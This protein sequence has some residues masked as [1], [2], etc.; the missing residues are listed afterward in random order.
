MVAGSTTANDSNGSPAP[1][2]LTNSNDETIDFG[3]FKATINI[4]KLTNGTNNDADPTPGVPDGPVVPVGSTVTWTYNVTNPT[5]VAL[6]NVSVTDNI[7]GVNP[8]PVLSGGFNVG[9]SNHDGL[10]EM[11]ETWVFTASGTAI[12]GQYSNI[13]TTTGTP[14]TPTGGSIPG[15]TPVTANNPDHYYGSLS[16]GDFVW[17]DTNAN[18]IQDNNDLTGNGINGVLVDLLDSHGTQ[19]ASTTTGNNPVGGAP[20]YYQFSGLLQGSYTVVIDASNF[21]SGGALF[22]YTATPSMVAGSTTA[23]DSNGSPAPV[24]LTNANDETIDFGYFKATINIVK[25]TNGTNNDS[26]P[27]PGVPDGPTV[28]V[29]STV[30]WTYNVTNPTQVALSN[31]SVTDNIAG[32]NPTPVLSGGFNVGDSNHDGLLEMGETWVFTASGTAIAGQYSN[33]GTTTG[34]PVTPTGGSIPGATPVTANNPDHY[35]GT[36][37][38]GDFIWND[39]N[40]N[41][42]QDSN[43]LTGNGINGVLVDLKNSGGTVIATTITGNNPVGGAPGYYQFSGLLQ[44]TYTVVIDSSNFAS[45]GPLAGYTVTPSNAPGSTTA[46]DSNGSPA[47]VTLTNANDETIDFGYYK[48]APPKPG[49]TTTPSGSTNLCS[50]SISGFKFLDNSG[51]GFSSDDTGKG[52]VTINL[53]EET[54]GTSGLQS[55]GDMLVATTMTLG[56]GSYTFN[57][58]APGTYYVQE[59]VPTGYIQ[60]GGGP[61]GPA[62]NTYF[63]VNATSGHAYANYDFDDFMLLTCKPTN[64]SY[65][66]TAPNGSYQTVSDMTGKTVQGATV[67][68]TFT[69]TMVPEMLTLASY[70]APSASFSDSNA[71]QQIFFQQA[72][73]T[74]TTPGT[75][76]LT[77]KIPNC[78]YQ[79]DF[80]CGPTID[81]LEPNQN[82]NAYGPD[83]A[84]ILYTPQGRLLDADNGGTVCCSPM[85]PPVSKNYPTPT[86]TSTCSSVS[87]NDSATISGGVNPKGTV[88]FYLM[89]PGST[90]STPLTSAVYTDVVTIGT[91]SGAMTGNGTYLTASMGNNP[92]GFMAATAGTYQWVVVYSSSDANN[93]SATSPFGNEPFTVGTNTPMISTTPGGTVIIGCG[94]KLTDSAML[95]AGINPGGTITFYLMGPGATSSTP[96]SAAV[97]TDTVTVNGNGTYS[98]ASGNYPG[99]YLPTAAGTYQWIAVYSGDGQN[100]PL[101]SKFGD[102][103]EAAVQPI[104]IGG[105]VFCDNNLNGVL[106]SGETLE[107]GAQVSLLSGTTVLQTATTGSNGKY[108][109]GNLP[110]GTYTVKLTSPSAGDLAEQ[111]HGAVTVAQSYTMTL[112]GGGSSTANNFAQIDQGS[113]SG[114]VFGDINDSGNCDSGEGPVAGA[115]VAL[116]GTDYLGN[117]VSKTTTTNSS[118]QFSFTGLLP[119]NASGYAVKVTPL[120]G[121]VSGIDKPGN[122]GGTAVLN[123]DGSSAGTISGIVLPGCNNCAVNYNFGELSIC[124]GLTATI[125]FWHN[126]NGQNLIKSFGTTSSGQS[127]ANW[128][129]TTYPNLF[130]NKAPAFSVSSTIGTNLTGRSNT[131]VAN[132]F[133]SLFGVS[134]QKAYAQVL[135]TALSVFT[136]TSTL[137]TGNV[138]YSGTT[139]KALATKFGFAISTVGGGAANVIVPSADWAAFGISSSAGATKTVSLLLSLAN[140][141]AVSGKLNNGNA[142]LITETNDL[143]NTIN[144]LGNIH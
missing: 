111:S 121:Q 130:G 100:A 84:N 30:T 66:I 135:A 142:T 13:G 64:V 79:I 54:N 62:G 93:S 41:G 8:T 140:Q 128:L 98:T 91:N 87:L 32:V 42:I 19:I 113:V 43:D 49:L 107:S 117:A 75:Y 68:V 10:L 38:L 122:F 21:N 86:V 95:A 92:G 31:V 132:Y 118:G 69:V 65:K 60:T 127:L 138:T 70:V 45:G 99:G 139:S 141:Y 15:A 123:G 88:T 20:G 3:Y 109:F 114:L 4:V 134:G 57:N 46:N 5:G 76:S 90:S 105:T 96:L 6:S 55:P 72:T 115:T 110:P 67:T 131:D 35:Y 12:A 120:V 51:N 53:Y 34:T 59:S 137:D 83:S 28:P 14:V 89:P 56:D 94:T 124:K 39:I 61:N 125:G 136:T 2:T 116:T 144:N 133:L 102:E 52:G 80:I 1:V 85:P 44:G 77:V 63:T 101:T 82:N 106:D 16:L 36:L 18:G 17:N 22:G 126:C 119:S 73:Q 143:F 7:A 71:Y 129:A 24:T 37:S 9:D 50:T 25:L 78:Y 11:G 58:L 104:T 112:A 47:P 108:S 103:P 27:V 40:A 48:P 97:Y 26:P 23:N 33:I 29:G 74:Y 81:Q